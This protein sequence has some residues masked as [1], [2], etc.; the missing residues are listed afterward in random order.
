M[1]LIIGED[2]IKS[3]YVGDKKIAKVYKG[4]DLVYTAEKKPSRLPDG[5]TEV[6]YIEII[7]SSSKL[8]FTNKSIRSNSLFTCNFSISQKPST[9]SYVLNCYISSSSYIQLYVSNSLSIGGYCGNGSSNEAYYSNATLGTI[10]TFK[11]D[12]T[13]SSNKKV[14]INDKYSP[15][16]WSNT[17]YSK[18]LN[19]GANS[20]T[21]SLIGGRIYH[22][23]A[24]CSTYTEGN[25]YYPYFNWELVPC[26]HDDGR[27]GLY[28]ITN[29]TPFLASATYF[30]A[31]PEV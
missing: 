7:S 14:Y 8:N 17:S 5:Y 28:D 23:Q 1:P 2:K 11:I 13:T 29:N 12:L 4:S 26:V 22:M 25:A 3:I 21:G 18:Y 19:I 6:K 30:S 10:Y 20:S 31:G 24:S 16:V 27:V 15:A 9:G